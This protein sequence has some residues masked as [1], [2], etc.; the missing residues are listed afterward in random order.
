MKCDGHKVFC[1]Y[2][3]FSMSLISGCFAVFQ[4]CFRCVLLATLDFCAASKFLVPYTALGNHLQLCADRRLCLE[5]F[6]RK[7]PAL[8]R[9]KHS[10]PCEKAHCKPEGLSQ[11]GL[12]C[13]S[14]IDGKG[15]L[16]GLV[17]W[18]PWEHF[19]DWEGTLLGA[20]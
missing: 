19:P 1:P 17:T 5:T 6:R 11:K 15:T 2:F 9:Q 8:L 18:W 13:K 10:F 7:S 16:I 4:S 12:Q 14:N 20:L 3:L